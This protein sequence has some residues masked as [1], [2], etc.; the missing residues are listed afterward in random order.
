[1]PDLI[2]LLP[3]YAGLPFSE[4]VLHSLHFM[5]CTFAVVA[6]ILPLFTQKGSFE[7]KIGGMIYMPISFAALALA[8]YMAWQEH[9]FVL[10]CFDAFCAYLLLSGWRALHEHDTPGIV[11]WA[12]P[13]GLLMLSLAVTLHVFMYDEGTRSLYLFGF[14]LNGFYLCWRDARHL[15]R[16]ATR[17]KH[18]MF[19]PDMQFGPGAPALWMNRYMTGMLGSLMANASVV[20]LTLMPIELHWLWPVGLIGAGAFILWKERSRKMRVHRVLAPLLQPDFGRI[21][22]LRDKPVD[23]IRR[24]A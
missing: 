13:A 14:A 8:S 23:D 17:E 9:S 20:V 10:F 16:R 22:K 7:F 3:A 2:P 18:K 21:S 19:L 6:A 5:L 1:V 12:L 4:Q 11:D 15:L 24:A